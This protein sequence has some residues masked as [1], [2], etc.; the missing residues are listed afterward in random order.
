MQFGDEGMARMLLKR[1]GVL[2]FVALFLCVDRVSW[3]RATALPKTLFPRDL[4]Q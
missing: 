2:W 1:R 4:F 3:L